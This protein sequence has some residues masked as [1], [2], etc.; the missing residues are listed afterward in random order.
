MQATQKFLFDRDFD[1]LEILREIVQQEVEELE[2]TKSEPEEPPTPVAPTYS[3]EDLAAA[4]KQ[5]YDKGKQG[6]LAE[7][8]AGIEQRAS[9]V[10]DKIATDVETLFATQT[11]YNEATAQDAAQLA[12]AI[13]RK[14]F[15]KLYEVHGLGEIVGVTEAILANLIR[16]P[17]LVVLVSEANAEPVRTRLSDFLAKRGFA[18][19]L[20]VRGEAALGAADCRIEWMGGDAAR[21]TAALFAEI[22]TIVERHVGTVPEIETPATPLRE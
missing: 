2:Q 22:E 10:L 20:E 12:L 1:D 19:L 7:A 8:L 11:K 16:E 3:E 4:R 14:L 21:D 13:A 17:R 5:A 6:G 9:V 15:P 18:G